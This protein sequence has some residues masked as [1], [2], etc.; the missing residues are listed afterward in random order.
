MTTFLKASALDYVDHP[1][2]KAFCSHWERDGEPPFPFADWV[3]EQLGDE[4]ANAVEWANSVVKKGRYGE[5][6]VRPCEW[7]IAGKRYWQWYAIVEDSRSALPPS[8]FKRLTAVLRPSPSAHGDYTNHSTAIADFIN[9]WAESR[10]AGE[11]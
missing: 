2:F 7:E 11:V 4:E 3:R 8:V 1:E 10:R 6:K 9:A 5:G